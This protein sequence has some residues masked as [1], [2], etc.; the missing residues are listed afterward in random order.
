[1]VQQIATYLV[2]STIFS[3]VYA[4]SLG[5]IAVLPMAEFLAII[6]REYNFRCRF[7]AASKLAAPNLCHSLSLPIL[8]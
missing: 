3:T 4:M 6:Q 8:L 7:W 5:R 2:G 1:M